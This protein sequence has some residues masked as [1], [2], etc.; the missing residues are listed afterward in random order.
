[1]YIS[2][3][4][5]NKLRS[6]LNIYSPKELESTFANIL[7][8]KKQN[9][10]VNTIYENPQIKQH[11]I[12]NI[13]LE[14]VSKLKNPNSFLAGDLSINFLNHKKRPETYLLIEQVFTSNFFPQITLPTRVMKKSATLFD[15][16]L[17]IKE[18]AKTICDNFTTSIS[19]HF[20]QFLIMEDLLNQ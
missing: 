1:M 15:K 11:K 17:I 3:K 16:I 14:L 8:P 5:S 12:S 19:S 20:L 6:D 4:L 18:E 2:Q 9:M 13:F 10:I 7:T